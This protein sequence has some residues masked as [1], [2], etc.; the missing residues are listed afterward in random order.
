MSS[1]DIHFRVTRVRYRHLLKLAEEKYNGNLSELIRA[2]LPD[3]EEP[4][5]FEDIS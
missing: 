3:Y 4:P 1:T 5:L 2:C